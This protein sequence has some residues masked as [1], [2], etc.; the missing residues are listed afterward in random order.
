MSGRSRTA[1]FVTK[2]KKMEIDLSLKLDSEN[3]EEEH[4]HEMKQDRSCEDPRYSNG[5]QDNNESETETARGGE[6]VEELSAEESSVR[7]NI[8]SEELSSLQTE[9]NR[10]KEENQVLKKVVE[11]TMKDYCDLQKKLAFLQKDHQINFLSLNGNSVSKEIPRILDSSIEK[12]STEG[13]SGSGETDL[14]LSLRLRT[15]TGQQ[16][17]RKDEEEEESKEEI[18][19]YDPPTHNKLQKTDFTE[20][21]G[22]V[23]SP[24]PNRK[25]RVS[26]RARCTSA[27]MNDGCQWRKY[28]QKIAKGNPC[29]R[30]YYRCTVSPGCPVRK[31]V[32]R[33]Q[34]DM[35]ILITTYEGTHNHPLPVG[36]T[37]MASTAS[38]ASSFVLLD[39]SSCLSTPSS[40]PYQGMNPNLPALRTLNPTDPSKGIVLDLTSN[41]HHHRSLQG[42]LL[43]FPPASSSI[44]PTY[45]WTNSRLSSYQNNS[46]TNNILGHNRG[47]ICINEEETSIAEN[48][49]KIASDPKFRVAVAAAITS[50]INKD[51]PSAHA[52]PNPHP[53][54]PR[55]GESG[56]SD[57]Q[58]SKCS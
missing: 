32:Q 44:Q 23:A 30:A 46:S 49:T 14:G 29:P 40:F 8:K 54:P 27:T 58:N 55:D 7:K 51:N 34:E 50:L 42:P 19:N 17:G 15:L 12:L 6:V 38:A 22:H 1:S 41:T 36:A 37:A 3:Q 33:C 48:V 56:N 24:P 9:M 10:M 21:A 45:G 4:E 28:G 18:S 47:W 57:A 26:V 52:H 13:N 31:Q 20:M 53:H 43:E 35:S 25:A 11:Q 5:P 2:D 16:Q 39:S